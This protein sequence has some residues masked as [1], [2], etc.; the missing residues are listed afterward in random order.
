MP[1]YRSFMISAIVVGLWTAWYL[2][3]RAGIVAAGATAAGLLLSTFVPG[4]SITVYALVI[5]WCGALYFVIPKLSKTGGPAS[6]LSAGAV[7][8]QVGSAWSWAKKR[9]Q[10]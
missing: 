6:S 2:G 7:A 5:A 4:A 9:L 10:R 3:V 8:A 1:C